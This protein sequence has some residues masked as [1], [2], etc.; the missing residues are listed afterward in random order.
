M[1]QQ[2][3]KIKDKFIFPIVVYLVIAVLSA[4]ATTW[5]NSKNAIGKEQYYQDINKIS[6]QISNLEIEV[7]LLKE[8]VGRWETT[9]DKASQSIQNS[10]DKELSYRLPKN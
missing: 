6:L 7:R 2:I 9:L 10:L 4:S 1:Q 3:E 8:A 5:Y